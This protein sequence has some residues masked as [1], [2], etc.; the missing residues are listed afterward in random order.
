MNVFQAVMGK[1]PKNDKENVPSTETN[2]A[3]KS[4]D[5]STGNKGENVDNIK[6]ME[7]E[8][9]KEKEKMTD[10]EKKA[11]ITAAVENWQ[12]SFVHEKSSYNA[13]K[14]TKWFDKSRIPAWC[15]NQ[16]AQGK[17][18]KKYHYPMMQ[19][20]AEF[21]YHLYQLNG[22]E[23]IVTSKGHNNFTYAD[24]SKLWSPSEIVN[25]FACNF[26]EGKDGTILVQIMLYVD[27]GESKS[28]GNVK[29]KMFK[30]LNKT[31]LFLYTY[32]GKAEYFNCTTVGFFVGLYP[33][34]VNMEDLRENVNLD[35][36]EQF[37][38]NKKN[39]EEE[40]EQYNAP[41]LLPRVQVYRKNTETH[42]GQRGEKMF[43]DAI[44]VDVPYNL[45]GLY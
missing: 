23:K 33:E 45:R 38:C 30:V 13:V 25:E 8:D 3:E 14:I 26:I 12:D 32:D 21:S 28:F 9:G 35:I 6:P 5:N 1:A 44:C 18:D 4:Q 10:E 16:E 27:Y 29:K 2:S 15:L 36:L 20:L 39:Y 11:E 34:A 40:I 24:T 22:G 42:L 17:D 31:K 43:I 7:T 19:M 41:N 37:V